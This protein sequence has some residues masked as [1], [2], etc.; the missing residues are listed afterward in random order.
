MKILYLH[1]WKSV[2]GGA[3]PSYL[4][5][6]GHYVTEPE[7][8]EDDFDEALRLAQA[9]FDRINP[10]VVVGSSRGGALAMNLNS[11]DV[12][13]VLLCPAWKRW[14]QIGTVKPGTQILH[15]REDEVIPFDE[16]LELL[17]TSGLDESALTVTG[18]N[19]R[20]FDPV[21]LADMDAAVSRSGL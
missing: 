3:K 12:P 21:S 2:S 15:S 10:E 7:L 9:E 11:E 18:E 8:P 13:L 20:L 14:G 17:R 16:T 4:A 6:Q 19:H 5:E 1:G